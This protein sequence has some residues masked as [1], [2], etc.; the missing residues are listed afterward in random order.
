MFG[1]LPFRTY[2]I[3]K[4]S[5]QTIFQRFAGGYLLT[6]RCKN[7]TMVCH[8]LLHDEGIWREVKILYGI[9]G[10]FFPIGQQ[11]VDRLRD[12]RFRDRMIIKKDTAR[13]VPTLM[14]TYYLFFSCSFNAIP[15]AVRR[16]F[17]CWLLGLS[18]IVSSKISSSKRGCIYF[19]LKYVLSAKFIKDKI[20]EK[21]R[22]SEQNSISLSTSSMSVINWVTTGWQL[23]DNWV[24]IHRQS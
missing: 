5:F 11:H 23:G 9:C 8:F 2:I 18:W 22:G 6:S 19:F 16:Y 12:R 20:S 1:I 4:Y 7:N 13:S 3:Q 17:W 10:P 24:T 15:F 14:F 21:L